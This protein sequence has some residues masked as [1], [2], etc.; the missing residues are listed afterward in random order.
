M[1]SVPELSLGA[2]V[3]AT[4]G[5]LGTLRA[6][7][8]DPATGAV[9]HLAVTNGE[10]PNSARLVPLGHVAQV[11]VGHAQLDLSRHEALGCPRLVVPG[12]IPEAGHHGRDET[13]SAWFLDLASGEYTFALRRRLPTADSVLLA[14][15]RH[16]E[17]GEGD[18]LGVID[19][20]VVDAAN[21]T[22]SHLVL[23]EGHLLGRRQVLIPASRIVE[24]TADRVRVDV[25]PTSLETTQ[26]ADT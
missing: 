4:D 12:T 3:R 10:V 1:T 13:A 16:V 26:R 17:S 8:V 9:S 18:H 11:D 7:I 21:G 6:L 15:G 20:V 22:I 25:S 5:E 14:R 23:T 19:D 24:I 2:K